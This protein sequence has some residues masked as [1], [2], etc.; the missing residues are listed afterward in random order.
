MLY[1][2]LIYMLSILFVRL[3]IKVKVGIPESFKVG[4]YPPQKK[5]GRVTLRNLVSTD[6]GLISSFTGRQG[7]DLVPSLPIHHLH[8][9]RFG[10]VVCG[11]PEGHQTHLPLPVG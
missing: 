7:V 1:C 5:L 3:T 8:H 10:H 9:R 4:W 11:S 2:T 6:I